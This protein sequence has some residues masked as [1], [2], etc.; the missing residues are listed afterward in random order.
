LAVSV[1]SQHKTTV[2]AQALKLRDVDCSLPVPDGT[3]LEPPGIGAGGEA[4]PSIER[5]E[6]VPD[7]PGGGSAGPVPACDVSFAAPPFP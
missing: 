3:L 5:A 6:R 7:R 4:A 1:E 2:L